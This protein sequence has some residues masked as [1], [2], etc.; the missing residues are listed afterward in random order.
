[1]K[2]DAVSWL[3]NRDM[4]QR[5]PFMGPASFVG[6]AGFFF[7]PLCEHRA[8]SESSEGMYVPWACLTSFKNSPP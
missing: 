3:F 5:S 4:E 8:P 2:N 6:S 7:P 1:M